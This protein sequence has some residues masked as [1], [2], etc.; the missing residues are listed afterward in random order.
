MDTAFFSTTSRIDEVT[1]L[2]TPVTPVPRTATYKI[3]YNN[4]NLIN[5]PDI[6]VNVLVGNIYS[7]IY[8]TVCCASS[9]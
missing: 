8:S 5:K 7:K 1:M 2:N 9:V 3:D 4:V 6:H